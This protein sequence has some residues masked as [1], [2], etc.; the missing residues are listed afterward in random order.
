MNSPL[1]PRT[2]GAM[3]VTPL[4]GAEC[5]MRSHDLLGGLARDGPAAV[6]AVRRADGGVEKAEVVVDLGDGADGGARAAA[7][8]LLLDGDGRAEAFD[9]VDVGALDLVEEL[10][11][12]GGESFDV[13]ALALGVDGVEGERRFTGA[14]EAG[15]HRQ[16]VARD[17][18]VDVAQIVLARAA[19]R[20]VTDGHFGKKAEGSCG[21]TL[22]NYPVFAL[23]RY[24]I[25]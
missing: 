6:G 15:D 12:V 13:A 14:G 21:V 7:G 24:S 20:N 23:W 11:R 10:A 1:R 19:H 2:M 22:D 25:D 16:R 9:G 5:R 17:A 18:D 8:G 4:A 3:T